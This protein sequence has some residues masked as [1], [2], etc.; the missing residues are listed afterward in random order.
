VVLTKSGQPVELLAFDPF[1]GSSPP[2]NS[3]TAV[4]LVAPKDMSSLAE[5]AKQALTEA[6]DA[7]G[8]ILLDDSGNVSSVFPTDDVLLGLDNQYI[9][10]VRRAVF[11][12]R[13]QTGYTQLPGKPEVLEVIASFIYSCPKPDWTSLDWVVLRKGMEIPLCPLHN[14]SR[15]L[16]SKV[17]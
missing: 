15:E 6:I 7:E 11:G 1:Q 10:D 16:K 5:L 8:V 17:S 9:D 2:Q 4:I 14:I 3:K 13:A 12:T